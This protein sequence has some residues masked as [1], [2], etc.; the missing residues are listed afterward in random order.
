MNHSGSINI[1]LKSGQKFKKFAVNRSDRLIGCDR[2]EITEASHKNKE[3]P[4][5][6]HCGNIGK[7]CP[8]TQNQTHRK[9]H[10]NKQA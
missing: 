3:T 9:C 10:E 8:K 1:E 4:Q 6:I 7:L 2:A 5:Q